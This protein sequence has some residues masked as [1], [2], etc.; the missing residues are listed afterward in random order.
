[1]E[2]VSL[3]VTLTLGSIAYVREVDTAVCGLYIVGRG[4]EYIN[5]MSDQTKESRALFLGW[6]KMHHLKI[7]NSQ[8][9]ES[10]R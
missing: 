1:M 10:I 5:N 2:G 3:V 6:C 4:M 8:F 9:F 7:L